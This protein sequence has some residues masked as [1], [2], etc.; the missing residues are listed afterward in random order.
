MTRSSSFRRII[1]L[2]DRYEWPDGWRVDC[3]VCGRWCLDGEDTWHA[4]HIIPIGLGG[5]D[6]PDNGQILCEACHDRKTNHSEPGTNGSDKRMITKS[7]RIS[8]KFVLR[9]RLTQFDTAAVEVSQHKPR[10]RWPYRP[11]KSGP[12]PKRAKV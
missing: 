4:D 5:A 9:K 12:F 10:R 7:K 3:A 11:I 8:E 6:H 2:R 1:Y